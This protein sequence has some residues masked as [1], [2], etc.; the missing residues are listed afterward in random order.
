MHRIEIKMKDGIFDAHAESIRKK[1]NSKGFNIQKVIFIRVFNIGDELSEAELQKLGEAFS[2]R[3]A[4]E[5][6][7]KSNL[8]VYGW[9]VEV[10]YLPGVTD[11]PA[12]VAK[13]AAKKTIGKEI[14]IYSSRVYS[15]I[16][17]V[18]EKQMRE[19]V[20]ILHNPLIER[21]RTSLPLEENFS[22][23]LAR[24]ELKEKPE[25]KVFKPDF[26]VLKKANEEGSLA[27]SEKEISAI[28]EFF[29]RPEVKVER[30]DVGLKGITDV[31]LEAI[32][33]TWSE[34]CKHKIF[35]AIIEYEDENGKRENINSLFKTYIVGATNII[36]SSSIVSVFK[37]NGGVVWFDD[38]HYI[39]AK[40]ETHNAPSALDPYGGALTG[41]LGVQR[42]VLG[43]GLGAKPFANIDVLCFA[44]LNEKP[45]PGAKSPGELFEGVVS[46]IRDG[47]NKTGIPTVN[48]SVVFESCFNGRPLVYAGTFGIMP[49]RI[50]D[51]KSEK[52]E[53]KPGYL[54][55]MVGGR[56]GKDGVHGATASS[57]EISKKTPMGMVQLG[58][59]FMQKKVIDFVLEAR[60]RRLYEGITDN[61]AGGLSSSIGELGVEGCEIWLDKVP[62][63]YPGLHPWEILVSESQERMTLAVKEEAIPELEEL[64]KKHDVE[65][66][67]V[68]KFT[69]TGKFVV[70][71]KES[72][73]AY[74]PSSFLHHPPRMVLKAKWKRKNFE[75][76]KV[77]LDD[78][79]R[80]LFDLLK[81]PN[82]VSK[83]YVIRQYDH[84]VQ[85]GSV[86]KPLVGFDGP[87]DA[88][89]IR[90]LLHK[91]DAV[92]IGHGI[93]PK[94]IQ[95]PYDMAAMAFDEAVRNVVCAGSYPIAALDNFC[96]PNPLEDE[97]KLGA[98]VR[99]NK[100]LYDAAV[101]F[102]VPFISGK[103]SM[104]NDFVDR[105]GVKHSINPTIL[106][107][108][109]GIM[110]DASK[111]IGSDFKEAGDLIYVT[112]IT[113]DELGGSELY[114]LFGIVGNKNP[115]VN[116]SLNKK[117][118][119]AIHNA[120]V[121]ELL[122]SMHDVSDG[123]LAI[124]LAE[125]AIA[126][127][128][129]I[130]VDVSRVEN[131]TDK[132][133]ALL[134]SE[135]AGRVVFSIHPEDK[136][137]VEKLLGSIPYALIGRVR[138]D[139]RFVIRAWGRQVLNEDIEKLAG[140]WREF[141]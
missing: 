23:F 45:H 120:C 140:V 58:D 80:V 134:F 43:T 96:W 82:I 112:G 109:I 50:V 84:E 73:V 24:V 88:A 102:G 20:K 35:N 106:I 138:G 126:G 93:C 34:H 42:D 12:R 33:Q 38:S 94:Y 72:I 137:E 10:G 61:G 92:V 135:S 31:E 98:L 14:E 95:D 19:I 127:G 67:V 65:I 79:S 91:K 29:S 53:I 117:T 101:E 119:K 28:V 60:D 55:V 62:L 1:L 118:Y 105:N 113:K 76:R 77:Y 89:V 121:R 124:A 39:V 51:R 103:D 57:M 74:L 110:D 9:R 11:N 75:E 56:V 131:E 37:D 8:A 7:F 78:Y 81:M 70:K 17:N 4:E 87:G 2:D 22:P 133:E 48:G 100:A 44:P 16:G 139:S 59:A 136:E 41:V 114:K 32:A 123:G 68:G 49:S 83:E 36:P 30:E 71:Y 90:P 132:L 3:V 63:K 27:L 99:A 40:V 54:A 122:R 26:N 69:N 18:G 104:K 5:F 46:G 107:T 130:D 47:G 6:S 64:A 86:I 141:P 52:K 25:V 21:Y 108:A 111:A 13:E 116:F 125:C 66:S 128:I 15:F 97:E 129:G 115:K 85:G